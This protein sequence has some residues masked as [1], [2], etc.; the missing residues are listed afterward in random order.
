MADYACVHVLLLLSTCKPLMNSRPIFPASVPYL[1]RCS[2]CY[3]S[4]QDRQSLNHDC[5]AMLETVI[6]AKSSLSRYRTSMQSLDKAPCYSD[7]SRYTRIQGTY[8]MMSPYQEPPG[9]RVPGVTER[10]RD[11]SAWAVSPIAEAACMYR[12]IIVAS[13]RF[14]HQ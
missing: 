5:L 1:G 12:S 10:I 8:Q 14:R 3:C 9:A 2:R 6:G 7:R 13:I 4:G 11:K